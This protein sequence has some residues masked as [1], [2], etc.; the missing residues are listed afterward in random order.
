MVTL[1]SSLLTK[2]MAMSAIASAIVVATSVATSAT[3][4]ASTSA[5]TLA[6]DDVDECL[7]L[8]LGS[9]VHAQ[10]LALEYEAH[11]SIRVVE[12]DGY[13]LFLNVYYET[14]HALALGVHEG[15]YVAGIDLLVVKLTVNT[16]NLLVYIEDEVVTTVTVC[17]VL[18]EGEVEGVALLQVI[19][20]SFES[21]EGEAE[22]SGELEG[23]LSG[24]LLYELLYAFILGIHV[25]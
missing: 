2:L 11:A 4:I 1:N 14:I 23:M 6:G 17:L 15:D 18:G 24:C 22:A 13:C 10:H 9:I 21:L 16:K 12:V 3:T 5:T 20:L 19:E 25:V 7:N 8:L